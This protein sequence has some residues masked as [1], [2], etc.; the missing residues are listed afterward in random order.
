VPPHMR[1]R[2]SWSATAACSARAVVI[3]S[4]RTPPTRTGKGRELSPIGSVHPAIG[5]IRQNIATRNFRI[6]ATP[7]SLKRG[8]QWLIGLKKNPVTSA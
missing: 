6:D 5:T 4:I 8:W 7:A 1:M 2:P 3:S